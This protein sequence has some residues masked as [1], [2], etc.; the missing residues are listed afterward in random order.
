MDINW[1]TNTGATDHITRELEKLAVRV[2]Y[3]AIDQIHTASGASSVSISH[4]GQSTIHNPGRNLH[5]N[6]VLHA[7]E[8]TKN[9][10]S[11]EKFS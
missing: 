2:K 11:V 5:L 7:P 10:V 3:N 8:A 9:L 4:I 6:N 1:Y